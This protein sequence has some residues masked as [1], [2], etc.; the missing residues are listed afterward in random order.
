MRVR[1]LPGGNLSLPALGVRLRPGDEADVPRVIVERYAGRLEVLDRN[2]ATPVR[3]DVSEFHVGGGW[4]AVP[5]V[6][7]RVRRAEAE[8]HLSG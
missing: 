1:L 8:L 4:Y 7:G 5:G 2:P 6:D 3:V